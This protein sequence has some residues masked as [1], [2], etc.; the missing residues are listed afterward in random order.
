MAIANDV[1]ANRTLWNYLIYIKTSEQ[2][3]PKILMRAILLGRPLH[4]LS[5]FITFLKASFRDFRLPFE[6]LRYTTRG[7]FVKAIVDQLYSRN[8]E[9]F[10]LPYLPNTELAKLK[11]TLQNYAGILYALTAKFDSATRHDKRYRGIA[12]TIHTVTERLADI[13]VE[14]DR[15]QQ[16]AMNDCQSCVDRAQEYYNAKESVKA[17][18]KIKKDYLKAHMQEAMAKAT[19]SDERVGIRNQYD[20]EIQAVKNALKPQLEK[21]KE[22]KNRMCKLTHRERS[23]M[24]KIEGLVDI[25]SSCKGDLETCV[26]AAKAAK[27]ISG[28]KDL[29]KLVEMRLSQLSQTPLSQRTT[30]PLA[31]RFRE[32]PPQYS[33]KLGTPR[34][35]GLSKLWGSGERYSEFWNAPLHEEEPVA[36]GEPVISEVPTPERESREEPS[37]EPSEGISEESTPILPEESTPVPSPEPTSEP[38][39]E[40]KQE[41][42]SMH[43]ILREGLRARRRSIDEGDEEEW[44]ED[45]NVVVPPSVTASEEKREGA[46]AKALLA[47]HE[48]EEDEGDEDVQT[49]RNLIKTLPNVSMEQCLLGAKQSKQAKKTKEESEKLKRAVEEY[50]QEALKEGVPQVR[51]GRVGIK[52]HLPKALQS[53]VTGDI[54]TN[55][56]KSLKEFTSERAREE[57]CDTIAK[58][59]CPSNVEGCKRKCKENTQARKHLEVREFAPSLFEQEF[60]E[61]DETRPIA[62]GGLQRKHKREMQRRQI[63]EESMRQ[64]EEQPI[65]IPRQTLLGRS[66]RGEYRHMDRNIPLSKA[67]EQEARRQSRQSLQS[68]ER[69][70]EAFLQPP[71]R[72]ILRLRHPPGTLAA[73]KS[74]REQRESME[75]ARREHFEHTRDILAEDRRQREL[76]HLRK[77]TAYD[78]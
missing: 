12:K 53:R 14:Y 9:P 47:E 24:E 51:E 78:I 27:L 40:R 52:Q 50:R 36:E 75:K 21:L 41:K 65:V 32:A 28:D 45:V 37:P 33:V 25:I 8:I 22:L 23:T 1:T 17:Q 70:G 62:L 4:E 34:T 43:D 35:T 26:R 48:K 72:S 10:S 64:Q 44:E 63:A 61:E 18:L 69:E 7:R 74:M 42:K 73:Q 38:S 3:H 76:G 30:E 5:D 67:I 49:C 39:R 59:R 15:M 2:T 13:Y 20:I 68:E 60:E 71:R 55:M 19:T 54:D 11:F 77:Y 16:M 46:V 31:E 6:R 29:P 58:V 56:L 57:Y 66:E